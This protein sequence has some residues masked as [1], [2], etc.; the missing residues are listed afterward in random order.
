MELSKK[1]RVSKMLKLRRIATGGSLVHLWKGEMKIARMAPFCTCDANNP[2]RKIVRASSAEKTE[3]NNIFEKLRS[4]MGETLDFV[5]REEEKKG[6]VSFT[7]ADLVSTAEQLDKSLSGWIERRWI[8]I[9]MSFKLFVKLIA[10]TKGLGAAHA[11]FDKV[12]PNYNSR[13]HKANNF[14]A[15]VAL[16]RLDRQFERGMGMRR[17]VRRYRN[18]VL[19][20]D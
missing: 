12:E 15:Y 11:Y 6:D 19:Q 8:L 2:T 10:K 4:L 5:M 7:Q 17:A 14:P 18:G 1:V 16:Y 13:D 20:D 9:H 3:K